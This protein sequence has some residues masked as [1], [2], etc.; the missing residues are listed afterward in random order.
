MSILVPSS[1]VHSPK[2]EKSPAAEQLKPTLFNTRRRAMELASERGASNRLTALPIEEF[3]F[4][5]HKGTF[6][7]ALALRYGWSLSQMPVVCDFGS[8]FTM[9]HALLC[10][11]RCHNFVSGLVENTVFGHDVMGSRAIRRCNLGHKLASMVSPMARLGNVTSAF[12]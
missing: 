8:S 3:G 7:D 11:R 1:Q 2:R 10:Q 6:T 5:L 12:G 9:E 4:C